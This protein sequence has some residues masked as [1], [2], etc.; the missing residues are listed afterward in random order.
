VPKCNVGAMRATTKRA[1]QSLNSWSHNE[2]V[3]DGPPKPW[4]LFTN[5]HLF[6]INMHHK[7]NMHLFTINMHCQ[8]KSPFQ[9]LPHDDNHLQVSPTLHSEV[10]RPGHY[11]NETLRCALLLHC[12]GFVWIEIWLDSEAVCLW[13]TNI[14]QEQI[15]IS[16]NLVNFGIPPFCH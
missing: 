11:R 5:G 16:A 15:T 2:K 7:F 8:A 6:T 13:R 4:Y 3:Q 14:V 10:K 9:A 1:A 12:A